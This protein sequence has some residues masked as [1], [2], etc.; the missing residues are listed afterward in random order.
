MRG[1]ADR[2]RTPPGL[3]L[4]LLLGKPSNLSCLIVAREVSAVDTQVRQA[5]RCQAGLSKASIAN[6]LA[7]AHLGPKNRFPGT[8]IV[9]LPMPRFQPV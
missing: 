3:L 2:I 9:D 4:T 8:F 7:N 5:M 6:P 1:L